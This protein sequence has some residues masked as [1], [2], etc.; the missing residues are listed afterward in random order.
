MP[1]DT[2][3][4]AAARML[5]PATRAF[6]GEMRTCSRY[7]FPTWSWVD[8][9]ASRERLVKIRFLFQPA[10][11]LRDELVRAPPVPERHAQQEQMTGA[12]RADVDRPLAR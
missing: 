9:A 4:P 3:K 11:P 12:R 5:Q 7:G 8:S 2:S 6:E 10:A 1:A